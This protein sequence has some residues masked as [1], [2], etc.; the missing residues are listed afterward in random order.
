MLQMAP[1]ILLLGCFWFWFFEM[2]YYSLKKKN[3]G[4][5]NAVFQSMFVLHI[6]ETNV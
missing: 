3:A 6:Q 4:L 1:E 2:K 5:E